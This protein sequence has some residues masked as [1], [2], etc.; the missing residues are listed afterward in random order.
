MSETPS[1][2]D[3]FIVHSNGHIKRLDA[4]GMTGDYAFNVSN[5]NITM[6]AVE[7]DITTSSFKD[8]NKKPLIPTKPFIPVAVNRDGFAKL[9]MPTEA[10]GL[11]GII[12]TGATG[13][14]TRNITKGGVIKNQYNLD[15]PTTPSLY[16][17]DAATSGWKA[18]AC[19]AGSYYI[20]HDRSRNKDGCF[21]CKNVISTL[22][23]LVLL[24]TFY[25]YNITRE[26]FIM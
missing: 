14:T 24:Q 6:K 26:L 1:G 15:I 16:Y 7:T 12:N 8:S 5:G 19:N 13:F 10:N 9:E 18:I 22:F 2:N 17:Y 25:H 20:Q 23:D 21:K 3:K 11:C 4:A